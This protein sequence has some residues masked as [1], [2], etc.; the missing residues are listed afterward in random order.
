MKLKKSKGDVT[1]DKS[2]KKAA[3]K[4]DKVVKAE[5]EKHQQ[6][7]QES[8]KGDELA[9]AVTIG[10][11]DKPEES[12]VSQ[13]ESKPV[14]EAT[15]VTDAC[16]T[17]GAD[18]A[19]AVRRLEGKVGEVVALLEERIELGKVQTALSKPVP[20]SYERS[21]HS[22]PAPVEP[23]NAPPALTLPPSVVSDTLSRDQSRGRT[24][25]RGRTTHSPEA[26]GMCKGKAKVLLPSHYCRPCAQLMHAI[27]NQTDHHHH[28]ILSDTASSRRR[29]LSAITLLSEVSHRKLPTAHSRISSIT[30]SNYNDN[31]T[32][33]QQVT[34]P[35]LKRILHNLICFRMIMTTK[36]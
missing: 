21:H 2:S 5:E 9:S 11:E 6:K 3:V 20:H 15:A 29:T 27:F 8:G 26:C 24:L 32:T 22:K 1:D 7:E 23:T 19:G 30:L 28:Q 35:T 10:N 25:D 33:K 14:N 31:D 4:L 12:M 36:Q 34:I 13:R 18:L 17:T 16:S